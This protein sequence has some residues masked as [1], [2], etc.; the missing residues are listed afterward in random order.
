M[1]FTLKSSLTG[2]IALTLTIYGIR[3][4]IVFGGESAG[5]TVTNLLQGG[6]F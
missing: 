5:Q 1:L 2:T 3:H 6:N 4:A